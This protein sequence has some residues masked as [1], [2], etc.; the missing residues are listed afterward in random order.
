MKNKRSR[1]IF[2]DKLADA[3]WDVKAY[4]SSITK[5]YVR[6]SLYGTSIL[7]I[8]WHTIRITFEKLISIIYSYVTNKNK[9]EGKLRNN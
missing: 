2:D 1:P 4:H 6:S 8:L 3:P 9:E 7:L 5:Q